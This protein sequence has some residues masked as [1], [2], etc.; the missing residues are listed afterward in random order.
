M[1]VSVTGR[2]LLE[3][4][5]NSQINSLIGNLW[6]KILRLW[7]TPDIRWKAIIGLETY[8][9]VGTSLEVNVSLVNVERNFMLEVIIV[10]ARVL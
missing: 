1:I 5:A 9:M 4:F 7:G 3:H 8:R 6:I 10:L 2:L